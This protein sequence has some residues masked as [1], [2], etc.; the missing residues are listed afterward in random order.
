MNPILWQPSD[1]QIGEA[2]ESDWLENYGESKMVG[3]NQDGDGIFV[4]AADHDLKRGWHLIGISPSAP[5][6]VQS[7]RLMPFHEN[8]SRFAVDVRSSSVWWINH[9]DATQYEVGT[10]KKL[11]TV[12]L[13]QEFWSILE[14]LFSKST[15]I[16]FSSTEPGSGTG[17]VDQVNYKG[18]ITSRAQTK[19]SVSNA[20]LTSDGN[21]LVALCEKTG[22]FE[23]DFGKVLSR[24]ALVFRV[25]GLEKLASLPVSR[26][27]LHE[28]ASSTEVPWTAWPFRRLGTAGELSL[29]P[30]RRLG[31]WTSSP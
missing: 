31:V 24:E 25:T 17:R 29:W 12:T 7:D 27:N 18:R 16:A 26:A 13:G 22:N 5:K 11:R 30:F 10:D 6:K 4:A 23:P 14:I 15:L 28:R 19:C 9:L 21:Y 1:E 2:N 3:V 20:A 8:T